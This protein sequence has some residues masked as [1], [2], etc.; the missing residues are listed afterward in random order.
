MAIYHLSVKTVARSKGQSV[1]SAAAYRACCKLR[2]QRTGEQHDCSRLT[3]LVSADI[4]LPE[5]APAWASDREKLWNAA[6]QAEVR[7]N[8]TVGREFEIALPAE[9]DESGRRRL[10]LD[11]ARELVDRHG[12][13]SDVCI[14][15][16]NSAGDER[17]HYAHILCSTRRLG[18]S[19][20]G[21]KT[22][23]LD[24][25][26]TGEVVYWRARFAELQN[27]FF[28]EPDLA[29]LVDHRTLEAQGI[30]REPDG[31]I[32]TAATHYERR[33]GRL[34]RRRIELAEGVLP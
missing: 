22:R 8:A 25:L 32:G 17:N 29:E 18:P 10:A 26:K 27:L 28:K 5:G 21:E 2:D 33:T 23:E 13:A 30:D 20:F 34:S 31:H 4:V 11:F 12:F 16:P 3:G 1:T 24:D 9:L 15:Q 7:R 6:E 14:R 19:G